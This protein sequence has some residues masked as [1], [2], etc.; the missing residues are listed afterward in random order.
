M[1][2]HRSR[3]SRGKP[4]A[5]PDNRDQDRGADR[6]PRTKENTQAV[7]NGREEPKRKNIA[8]VRRV[9]RVVPED[10]H[11]VAAYR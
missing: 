5:N 6:S 10:R 2:V 1:R 9:H 8:R 4:R 3:A 11:R 7:S